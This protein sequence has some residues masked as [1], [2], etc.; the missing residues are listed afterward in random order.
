MLARI[1]ISFVA[2]LREVFEKL[3]RRVRDVVVLVSPQGWFQKTRESEYGNVR[4]ATDAKFSLMLSVALHTSSAMCNAVGLATCDSGYREAHKMRPPT[5]LL[6]SHVEIPRHVVS[7]GRIQ[8][9]SREGCGRGMWF[10]VCCCM[11]AEGDASAVP[12]SPDALETM[13]ILI[14]LP[15]AGSTLIGR[16]VAAASGWCM[17]ASQ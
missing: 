16:C 15:W 3:R 12:P 6:H 10:S 14:R 2:V 13:Q 17:D 8:T 7:V 1:P 4:V 11:N 5:C 9:I